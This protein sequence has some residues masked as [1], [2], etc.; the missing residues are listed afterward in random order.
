MAISYVDGAG[1]PQVRVFVNGHLT[2]PYVDLFAAAWYNY[3][4]QWFDLGGTIYEIRSPSAVSYH[5]RLGDHLRVFTA[6]RDDHLV[7][8]AWDGGV[9][10]RGTISTVR[11]ELWHLRPG[12][13]KQRARQVFP[14]GP[15][16]GTMRLVSYDEQVASILRV[17]LPVVPE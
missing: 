2:A 12:D 1:I 10:G 15:L 17:D 14:P 5:D 11:S 7:G 8:A 6:A 4:Y 16:T 3:E 13:D 9:L